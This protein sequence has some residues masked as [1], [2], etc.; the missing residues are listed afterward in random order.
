MKLN[1]SDLTSSNAIGSFRIELSKIDWDWLSDTN[2]GATC[3]GIDLNDKSV[4]PRNKNVTTET[5]LMFLLY[6][7]IP[8]PYNASDKYRYVIL[9]PDDTKANNLHL[10]SDF[11]AILDGDSSSPGIFIN[12]DTSRIPSTAEIRSIYLN[13]RQIADVR[14]SEKN[15]VIISNPIVRASTW[16]FQEKLIR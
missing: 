3:T 1:G 11:F 16:Y 8:N 13:D 14:F 6:Y 15:G 2:L 10:T 5:Q 7:E 4:I 9:T 12:I